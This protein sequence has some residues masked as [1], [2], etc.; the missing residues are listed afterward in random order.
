MKNSKKKESQ[1]QLLLWE[2]FPVK[3]SQLQE[4]KKELSESD[5]VFGRSLRGSSKMYSQRGQ[6]LKM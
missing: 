6:L 3:T 1:D 4:D 2:D 5:Q